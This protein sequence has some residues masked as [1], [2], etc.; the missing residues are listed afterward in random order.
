MKYYKVL[1][2]NNCGPYSRFDFTEYLPKDGKPG[3]WL[4]KRTKLQICAK[5]YHVTDAAHLIDW[6][7]AQIFEVEVRG[8]KLDGDNKSSHQSIRFI[9]KI[10]EWNDKSARLF[11]CWCVRQIWDS[12]IDERSKNALIV[13][14]KYANGEATEDELAAARDAAWDAASAAAWAAAR[15]AA[16]AAARAAAWAA[17]RAAAWAAARAAAWDAARDAAWDAARDAASAAQSR[18][19]IEILEFEE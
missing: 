9:R 16:W 1:D 3:K 18:H 8:D 11:A 10:E 14:E 15:A 19:L 7:D 12:L 6:L 4:P 2:K 13:A 17:A 5:G